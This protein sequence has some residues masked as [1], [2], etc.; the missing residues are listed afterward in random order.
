MIQDK[1]IHFIL[2]VKGKPTNDTALNP[3]ACM[4]KDDEAPPSAKQLR[5]NKDFE[6]AGLCTREKEAGRWK[7]V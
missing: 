3:E 6:A 5:N 7:I 4:L 1:T 2:D